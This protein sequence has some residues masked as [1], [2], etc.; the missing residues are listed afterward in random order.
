MSNHDSGDKAER[1]TAQV[2]FSVDGTK[3]VVAARPET[4][5]DRA[6]VNGDL[7]AWGDYNAQMKADS[8]EES[9]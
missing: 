4:D 8:E 1:Q 3:H 9:K 6:M 2:M 7:L 5:V